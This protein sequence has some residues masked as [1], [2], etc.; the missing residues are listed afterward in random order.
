MTYLA[1]SDHT[2][3]TWQ[4]ANKIEKTFKAHTNWVT[5]MTLSPD[6]KLLA[7]VS[8][9]GTTRIWDA[10][11]GLLLATLLQLAPQSDNWLIIT[12]QG[13]FN[14]SSPQVVTFYNQPDSVQANLKNQW[15]TPAKVSQHLGFDAK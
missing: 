3:V 2:I 14:A 13:T 8:L 1:G 7:S 11:E 9:D 10:K 12:S 5:H 4:R 15:Q 6:E